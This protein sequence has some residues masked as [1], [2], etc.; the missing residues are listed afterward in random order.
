VR[1]KGRGEKVL[2]ENLFFRAEEG[3]D[4]NTQTKGGEKRR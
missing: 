3:R 4:I 1:R 2:L